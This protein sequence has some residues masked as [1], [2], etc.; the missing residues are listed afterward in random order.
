[1]GFINTSLMSNPRI[2]YAMA[3]DGILPKIFKRVNEKTQVQQFALVFFTALMIIGLIWLGT[4]EKIVNYVMFI[5]SFSMVTAAATI[6]IFRKRMKEMNYTG[7]KLK[8]YPWIPLIFMAMLL[9]VTYNVFI[10]D[11]N[12]AITGLCIFAAGFPLYHLLKKVVKT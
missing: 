6:F 12:A 10:S 5:D 11:V 7:F 2:Y 9:S 3:E 4:F 1:M 8:F